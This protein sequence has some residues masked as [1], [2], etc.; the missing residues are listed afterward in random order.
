MIWW[1]VWFVNS[2]VLLDLK[3]SK[4]LVIKRIIEKSVKTSPLS[5]FERWY[6]RTKGKTGL[7]QKSAI[8]CAKIHEINTHLLCC[9]RFRGFWPRSPSGWVKF[10]FMHGFKRSYR[11][12]ENDITINCS[13]SFKYCAANVLRHPAHCLYFSCLSSIQIYSEYFRVTDVHYIFRTNDIDTVTWIG[14]HFRQC[15]WKLNGRCVMYVYIRIGK[16]SRALRHFSKY[17][18]LYAE[19]QKE[20]E[21]NGKVADEEKCIWSG[22]STFVMTIAVFL[23]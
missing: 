14:F 8:N 13:V 11:I 23:L 5:L 3:A 16:M 6:E 15:R 4:G 7:M 1:N 12:Y 19:W 10:D 22:C 2:F 18:K 21:P 9:P 17:W 20:K